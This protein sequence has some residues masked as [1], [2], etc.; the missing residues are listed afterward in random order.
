LSNIQALELLETHGG[1]NLKCVFLSHLSAENNTPE[2]ALSSF[3]K[4]GTKY[5]IR[6]TSRYEAGEV[7][8][9]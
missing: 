3:E 4:L 5:D 7:F 6:L 8:V 9:I 1:E 2:L